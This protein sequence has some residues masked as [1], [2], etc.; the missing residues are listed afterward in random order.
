MIVG[1]GWRAVGDLATRLFPH[2]LAEW[3][4]AAV[5]LAVIADSFGLPV[6]G[7]VM[8]LL[9]SVYAG[10]T[11]HLALP[12][13]IAAAVV[14]AIVGDN[15]TYFVGR[16]G[17]YP[18]VRRHGKK[19]HLDNH[20][21]MIGQ[22][23]FDRY[24]GSVVWF[25]RLIPVLH[26]WTAVLAGV[27]RMPWPRFAV[28]NAVGAVVWAGGLSLIGYAFGKTALHFGALIAGAAV[29][30]AILIGLGVIAL[31][32]MNERRLYREAVR[33]RATHTDAA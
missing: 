14:G 26:I 31:L 18:L 9:A 32:R 19:L 7:E 10:A 2:L 1:L 8:L 24:G 29:P 23:L 21:L 4:Y 16:R 27:N 12:A 22:Y 25:G 33:H 28:A 6:P 11:H 17:G 30:A 13:V 5:M 3:G 15:V 20:R